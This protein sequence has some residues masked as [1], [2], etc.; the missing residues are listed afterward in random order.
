MQTPPDSEN[1][2]SEKC[3]PHENIKF[4]SE[5]FFLNVHAYNDTD[6]SACECV[7]YTATN[8]LLVTEY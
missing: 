1:E 3:K 4:S 2:D 7:C 8:A 5:F 6:E